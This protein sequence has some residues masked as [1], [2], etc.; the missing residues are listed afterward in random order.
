MDNR[1]NSAEP[2]KKWPVKI[3]SSCLF[4]H[5]CGTDK[6][7]NSGETTVMKDE[8]APH[9]SARSTGQSMTKLTGPDLVMV[10][11]SLSAVVSAAAAYI[12]LDYVNAPFQQVAA[13]PVVDTRGPF[14]AESAR[15]GLETTLPQTADVTPDFGAPAALPATPLFSSP[16]PSPIRVVYGTPDLLPS[17]RPGPENR[18][19]AVAPAPRPIAPGTEALAA[20]SVSPPTAASTFA[21]PGLTASLRPEGRPADFVTV[22]ASAREPANTAELST[23]AVARAA[24]P[25]AEIAPAPLELA[26]IGPIRGAG[27]PC[28]SRLARGIPGRSRSAPGGSDVVG[29]LAGMGGAD[30]DARVLQAAFSG[31]VPDFLRNLRP[32]SFSGVT[33]TGQEAVVTICVTPDYLAVGS[34]RD[35]V[36]VPLG[37][38]AALQAADQFDMML[39]TPR[40]VD[41]IYAQADLQLNPQPMEP[42]AQMTSTNYF[43]RHD[44]L[45]DAQMLRAGGR[46]GLL[47]AGQKKDVVL[48]NR[49][50]SNPGRV[51]IYGWHRASG[52]PIQPLSTVH[53]AQY[54]DYSHGVRLVSRTAFVNGRAVDL[55]DLLTDARYAS[56][57]NSDGPITGRAEQMAALR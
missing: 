42:G 34:D 41:A 24:S 4:K 22:A 36:R 50:S 1:R 8:N 28:S 39:P 19:L 33:S 11:L 35:F 15:A 31:N 30:R 14:M 12:A 55:G 26:S 6:L 49:L 20:L 5:N 29:A 56:L 40:M 32:V 46:L 18:L 43:L 57:L 25:E 53:G 44:G 47:V 3:Q 45:V 13:A 9:H 38:P 37:L 2:G 51:A 54:A 52:S 17:Q 48:A 21:E 16:A 23:V 27:N 10:A 7:V